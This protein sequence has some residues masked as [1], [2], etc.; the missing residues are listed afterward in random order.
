MKK[1][2]KSLLLPLALALAFSLSFALCACSSGDS[3][4]TPPPSAAAETPD[5]ETPE[6]ETPAAETPD[7]ETPEVSPEETPTADSDARGAMQTGAWDGGTFAN[8]WA[9]I[10]FALPEGWTSLSED[11]IAANVKAQIDLSVASSGGDESIRAMLEAQ[12]AGTVMDFV[13][14]GPA[15]QMP[16][17]TATYVN[18]ASSPLT[19]NLDAEA[20][21]SLTTQQLAAGG[22]AFGET[23][24]TEIAGE[25]YIT[26]KGSLPILDSTMYQDLYVRTLDGAMILLT[27]GYSDSTAADAEAFLA[28]VVPAG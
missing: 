1:T 27:I 19:E 17:V 11:E 9:N 13:L 26:V 4:A 7:T 5:T 8:E 24:E 14:Y 3:D 23:S 28:S 10:S 25:K 20:Y 2:K 6:V 12:F 22:F 15:Q 18:A 21:T 16:T